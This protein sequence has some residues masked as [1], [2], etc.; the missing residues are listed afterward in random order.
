MS[1]TNAITVPAALQQGVDAL[2]R[3]LEIAHRNSG[4]PRIVARFLMSLY[5]GDRFPFDLSDFRRLDSEIFA[6]C[7]AV[8]QLDCQFSRK[9]HLYIKDGEDLW[10]R[11]AKRWDFNDH[12]NSSWR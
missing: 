8:L 3:L 1:T 11:L 6:D 10:E 2:I 4:Q 12:G 5:N 9:V 7:L